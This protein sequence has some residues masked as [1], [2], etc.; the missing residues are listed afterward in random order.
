MGQRGQNSDSKF[1]LDMSAIFG[2]RKPTQK[3]ITV[4][5]LTPPM[6]ICLLQ[7]AEARAVIGS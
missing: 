1:A 7:E 4:N 3:G 2:E 5:V 6:L